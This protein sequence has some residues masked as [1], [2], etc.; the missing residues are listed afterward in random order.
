MKKQLF[1]LLF[2]ALAIYAQEQKLLAILDTE[3]DG[4]P[5]MQHT[6][7]RYLTA[8]LREIAGKVLGDSYGIM[9]DQTLVNKLGKDNVKKECKENRGC[10]ANL[11]KK[12]NADYIGQARLGR[13]GGNLSIG[14]ELYNSGSGNLINSFTGNAKDI[15]GLLS[16]IDKEAPGMFKKMPGAGKSMDSSVDGGAGDLEKP[17]DYEPDVKEETQAPERRITMPSLDMK[18]GFTAGFPIYIFDY[19]VMYGENNIVPHSGFGIGF[20]GGPK[21]G[22][23][24]S[25]AISLN[26]EFNFAWK[27]LKVKDDYKDCNCSFTIEVSEFALSIPVLLKLSRESLYCEAGIQFDFPFASDIKW[28]DD[29]GTDLEKEFSARTKMD[30]GLA[31]GIGFTAMN[32]DFG[33][34][35]IY[36]LTKFDE[37]D[38]VAS[39]YTI[40]FIASRWF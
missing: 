33:A 30:I 39:L 4:E 25:D 9:T 34:R 6:E 7:L 18:W 28:Q 36:G 16:I 1:V 23:L 5:E 14:V 22:I 11:G 13:L 38:E 8:K 3:D 31:A 10:L 20:F 35:F 24:Y 32:M 19:N 17:D 27:S 15:F 26:A 40:Q 12:L 2:F 29:I 21:L 37:Y